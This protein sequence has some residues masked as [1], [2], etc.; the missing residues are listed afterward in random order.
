MGTAKSE[1]SESRRIILLRGKNLEVLLGFDGT[2]WNLPVAQIPRWKRPAEHLTAAL[3][4]TCGIDAISLSSLGTLSGESVSNQIRYEIMESCGPRD[5]A[6]GGKQWVATDTLV[7]SDFRDPQDCHAVL[8]ALAELIAPA[9][10]TTRTPFGRLGWFRNLQQWVQEEIGIHGLQLNGRFRQ[11]NACPT[12]SL[13]RFE[14]DGPA[15]WFKAAGV[16]NE[17]E[18][19]LTLAIARSFSRFLPQIIATRPECNGWLAREAEGPLLS[20]CSALASWETAAADLAQLQI[21]S[22]GSLDLLESGARD[23]STGALGVL[24]EPFLEAMGE[25]MDRQTDLTLARLSREQM[26]ILSLRVQEDLSFLEKT[27]IRETLGHMDFNP[28][29]IVCSPSGSVFL[30]WAEAFVGHP[31]LTF[32]YLLEH[33]RRTFGS[34]YE[35]QLV[36]RYVSPWRDFVSERDIQSALEVMPLLA[37]FAHA[38]GNDRWTNPQK[39]EEPSTAAYLR[40]LTRRMEREARRLPERS[41]YD[42][43]DRTRASLPD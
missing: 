29:N 7:A 24:V 25:V 8:Q 1:N 15:V 30:D 17:R 38:A 41:E 20:Q 33:F 3:R 37:V 18:Y 26:R 19:R 32:E 16:P 9:E 36:A 34:S 23:L 14:T 28:G 40:S 5:E 42:Q 22:L 11:V 31:F 2:F 13:I 27:S 39:L 6:P 4:A 43:V 21:C 10:A 35:T 12:F